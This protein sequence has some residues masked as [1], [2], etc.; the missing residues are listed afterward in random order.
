MYKKKKINILMISSSSVLGGGTKQ[1][2]TLGENLGNNFSI[3]YAIPKNNNFL[4]FL[5]SE[6]H[7]EISERKIAL[8]D[9]LNLNNF[10]KLKS[11]DI[12]HAHGKGASAIARILK[13]FN[14]I[15]LIYTFHGIHLECH[16]RINRFIYVLYEN[17]FG[18]LDNIKIFVSKSEKY[19]AKASNIF[20]GKN[21]LI[22]NNG[23]PKM[24][25]K[26]FTQ[27]NKKN[28]KNQNSIQISVISLCRFVTQKNIIDIVNIA[29]LNKNLKFLI[30]GSGPL[31]KYI[32]NYINKR[33]I[34][35]IHL[36]GEKNNVYK[37]L[38]KADIYLSTSLYEGF[39]ISIIEAMSIGLPIVASDVTG[40]CDTIENGKSGFLYNLN[41]VNMASYYLNKLANDNILR[42][43]IGD[44]AFKRQRNFFSKELMMNNYINLYGKFY[45]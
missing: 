13:I 34:K 2:F 1:M 12:I 5:D 24:N 33:K 16:K 19:Y 23:V 25:K 6:N 45:N 26:L 8:K 44:S 9:I 41:D 30:I 14:N 7:I 43:K 11:I 32:N 3:F 4:N 29:D 21:T 40:N 22:I 15:I 38:Y 17:L 10:I 20:F 36:L 39:P 35:N 27:N 42:R 28:D 31:W 18:R 37:Y